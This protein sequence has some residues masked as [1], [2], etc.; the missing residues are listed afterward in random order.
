MRCG[1]LLLV[2]IAIAGCP[3]G[4]SGLGEECGS[5]SDCDS[6]L[7]CSSNVCV[8]RCS[9]APECGDGYSCSGDGICVLASG[10]PGDTCESEVDCAPGLS[11][12]IDPN[13]V[14]GDHLLAS[15]SAQLD[16]KPAG[17]ACAV[18]GDCRNGTCAL[19]QCVDLC[20]DSRDCAIGAACT[21]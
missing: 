21:Q 9:R 15:C 4:S 10:Q 5:T 18:D 2:V 3:G 16:G 19:G 6:Q 11:C 8:P 14:V 1:F 20:H 12:Q 13:V 17:G 7:Q